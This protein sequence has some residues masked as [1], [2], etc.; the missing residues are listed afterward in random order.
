MAPN[1]ILEF[2]GRDGKTVDARIHVFGPKGMGGAS[3]LKPKK[4]LPSDV[5]LVCIENNCSG[6]CVMNRESFQKLACTSLRVVCG[7][8]GVVIRRGG[9]ERVWWEWGGPEGSRGAKDFITSAIREDQQDCH[10][11]L[12]DDA[13][14]VYDI[15]P[16]YITNIVAPVHGAL[17]DT[18]HLLCGA[19]VN[20]LD[21]ARLRTMGF[22]YLPAADDVQKEILEHRLNRLRFVRL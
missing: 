8:F 17:L 21:K 14:R 12:E 9:D 5:Y 22:V 2:K 16:K 20:G 6:N 11:W 15:V 4:L 3:M 7:S 13:G 18:S 1:V 10:F 19:V